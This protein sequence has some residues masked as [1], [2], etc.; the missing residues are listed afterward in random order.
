MGA[1]DSSDLNRVAGEE[2]QGTQ[3]EA[4]GESPPQRWLCP[5]SY[6]NGR[7][8]AVPTIDHPSDPEA[9][10][11]GQERDGILET[12][13]GPC[14]KFLLICLGDSRSVFVNRVGSGCGGSD[15]A[16]V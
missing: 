12:S 14:S 13:A 3:G 6:A 16:E 2:W 11:C 4:P 15:S 9:G 7:M 8:V 10:C 1:A 5:A